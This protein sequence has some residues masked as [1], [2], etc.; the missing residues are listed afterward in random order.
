MRRIRQKL[1]RIHKKQWKAEIWNRP[2]RR[3]YVQ[4]KADYDIELY[5]KLNVA[6]KRADIPL[7]SAK[8]WYLTTG[9]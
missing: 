7:C 3:N 4:I 6:T 2:K 5:V 8:N 1:L 9:N